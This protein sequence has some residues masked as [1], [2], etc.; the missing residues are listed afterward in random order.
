MGLHLWLRALHWRKFSQLLQTFFSFP[1]NYQ[2]WTRDNDFEIKT[3]SLQ[4][5]YETASFIIWASFLH[6]LLRRTRSRLGA[7]VEQPIDCLIIQNCQTVQSLGRSMDWILEDNMIDGLFFCASFTSSRMG[8]FSF[9]W[10]RK[11]PTQVWGRLK[12]KH[13]ILG[14]SI[15]GG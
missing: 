1:R 3:S 13:A 15:P 9:A 12:R 7:G 2:Q 14:R 8:H 5:C 10:E 11:R 4:G 6:P